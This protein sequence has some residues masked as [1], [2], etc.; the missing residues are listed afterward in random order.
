MGA[1]VHGLARLA[2]K[3]C[4][5]GPDALLL[6]CVLQIFGSPTLL[7]PLRTPD[8]IRSLQKLYG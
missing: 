4:L 2:P 8:I 1:I 3:A 7:A 6:W 5:Q